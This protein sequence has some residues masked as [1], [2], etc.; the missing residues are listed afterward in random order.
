MYCTGGQLRPRRGLTLAELSVSLAVIATLMVAIGS[1]MTLAG[2]AVGMTALQAGEARVDDLVATIA[3]EQRMALTVLERTATSITFTVADRDADG[4]PEKIQYSWSGEVDAPLMRKYNDNL[5]VPVLAK[6][7]QFRLTAVTKT[8]QPA[9]ATETESTT[10]EVVYA[11]E[12]GSNTG[13]S[14]STTSWP[15]Q[16]FVAKLGRSDATSWRVTG[17]Q[18]VASRVSGGTTGKY[19]T[20]S[21]CPSD[22]FGKPNFLAPVEQQ[23]LQMSSLGT[24]AGWSPMITFTGAHNLDP[25]KQYWVVVSQSVLT[26]TGSVMY[27]AST[28]TADPFAV[29]STSGSAWTV[30]SGRDMKVKVYGRYKYPAP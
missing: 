26:T 20:V 14:M 18:V 25:A 1:V 13:H 8:A 15:A 6:V 2:R 30:Y 9:A 23:T 28:A 3:S 19:W 7:K 16:G 17:V 29:T 21:L 5:A 27:A 11:Y 22:A 24:S 4:Q 12:S 10:D